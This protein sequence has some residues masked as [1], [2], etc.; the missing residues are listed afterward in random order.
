MNADEMKVSSDAWYRGM[1]KDRSALGQMWRTV[2]K[3]RG[4]CT[5]C[6]ENNDRIKEGFAICSLC[7]AEIWRSVRHE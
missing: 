5:L 6:G 2:M 4:K 7:A 1:C 3:R